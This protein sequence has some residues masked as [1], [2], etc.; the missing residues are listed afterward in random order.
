[1]IIFFHLLTINDINLTSQFLKSSRF[2][3]TPP[4]RLNFNG[5]ENCN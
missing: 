2:I 1:M 5:I 4:H 3:I